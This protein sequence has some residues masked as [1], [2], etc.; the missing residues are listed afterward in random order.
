LCSAKGLTEKEA[1][2]ILGCTIAAVSQRLKK[3]KLL[4]IR[5]LGLDAK[6]V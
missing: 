1:A 3:A 4:F 2:H 5:K 6:G